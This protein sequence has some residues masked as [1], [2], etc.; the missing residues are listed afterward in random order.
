MVMFTADQGWTHCTPVK[1]VPSDEDSI[2]R[3]AKLVHEP[4]KKLTQ[5]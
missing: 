5:L 2:W 3:L 4:R 1:R